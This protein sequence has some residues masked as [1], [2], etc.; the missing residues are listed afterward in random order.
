M[1]DP[2]PCAEGALLSVRGLQTHFFSRQGTVKAVDGLSFELAPGETLGIA[3]ESGCG[4]SVTTQSILRIV[5][6]NGAIVD[7]SI[8]VRLAQPGPGR[9]GDPGSPGERHT[10]DPRRRDR[11]GVPGADDVILGHAHRR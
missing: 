4:K 2:T 6:K 8:P 1:T 10:R 3:G 11:D 7:G 9:P 5:P